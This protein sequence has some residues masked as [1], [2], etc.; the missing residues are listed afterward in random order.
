M[1]A[2][3]ANLNLKKGN[4]NHESDKNTWLSYP[5]AVCLC[6]FIAHGSSWL[7]KPSLCLM[8]VEGGRG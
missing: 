6:S 1:M 5:T 2:H 7:H 3:G 4:I 8:S